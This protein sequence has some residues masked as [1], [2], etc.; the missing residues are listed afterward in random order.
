MNMD[1][2]TKTKEQNARP[3][4][5]KKDIPPNNPEPFRLSQPMCKG[6]ER[7]MRKKKKNKTILTPV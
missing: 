1:R 2:K 4:Q 6:N 3:G 7:L 5:A